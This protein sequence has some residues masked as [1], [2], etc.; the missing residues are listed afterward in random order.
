MRLI[1][2]AALVVMIASGALSV[3]RYNL[4]QSV[5]IVSGE[6]SDACPCKIV[7]T[8]WSHK[9][10]TTASCINLQVFRFHARGAE[11]PIFE[12]TAVLL[13]TPISPF[14]APRP[15]TLYI[16]RSSASQS[17]QIV[18]FFK[19]R[20][21]L[22]PRN[23]VRLVPITSEFAA[24]R[25]YVSIAGI[26]DYKIKREN[27]LLLDDDVRNSMYSWLSRPEQWRAANVKLRIGDQETSYAGSNALHAQL[28]LHDTESERGGFR[29]R[30]TQQCFRAD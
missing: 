23:G 20:F 12:S 13:N 8:C 3:R 11:Q 7:C 25:Q 10:S 19:S 4:S 15:D 1:F 2:C 18:S 28:E 27:G 9:R 5:T 22:W 21:H 16:D 29:R 24:D 26:L 17:P 6:W 14:D 30:D